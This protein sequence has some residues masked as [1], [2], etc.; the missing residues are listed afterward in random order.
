M[1]TIPDRYNQL[2]YALRHPQENTAIRLTAT[3]LGKR[4]VVSK[5]IGD[6]ADDWASFRGV[7]W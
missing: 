3:S 1:K 7:S 5:T 2:L 4:R 6:L